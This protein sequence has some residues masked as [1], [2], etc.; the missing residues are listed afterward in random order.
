M[1]LK[2]NYQCT[3]WHDNKS[4]LRNP[5]TKVTGKWFVMFHQQVWTLKLF[6]PTN[7]KMSLG[8]SK[9]GV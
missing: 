7:K 6:L 4:M 8:P 3:N 2:V 1:P 9:P 5:L